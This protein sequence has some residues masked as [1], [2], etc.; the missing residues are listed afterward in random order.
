MRLRA[1]GLAG[2]WHHPVGSPWKLFTGRTGAPCR[3]LFSHP[4][5][6]TSGALLSLRFC[7][8]SIRNRDRN[9]PLV[10]RRV[11][12]LAR[13]LARRLCSIPRYQLEASRRIG[14]HQLAE[15]PTSGAANSARFIDRAQRG[16]S[17][18]SRPPWRLLAV[19]NFHN[20]L[21]RSG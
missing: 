2:G 19:L 8:G 7:I 11:R 10:A 6:S 3:L 4:L 13:S 12:A 9:R 15:K 21:E 14:V 20:K 5:E 17:L 18:L 16:A 1:G